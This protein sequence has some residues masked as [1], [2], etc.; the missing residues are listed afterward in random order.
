[1]VVV[2]YF[3]ATERASAS[4]SWTPFFMVSIKTVACLRGEKTS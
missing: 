2:T 3:L 1:M 4:A